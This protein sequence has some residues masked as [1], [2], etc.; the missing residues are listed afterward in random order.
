MPNCAKCGR[1]VATDT[2]EC[3]VCLQ[4]RIKADMMRL[5]ISTVAAEEEQRDGPSDRVKLLVAGTLSVCVLAFVLVVWSP[6]SRKG[7]AVASSPVTVAA[8]RPQPKAQTPQRSSASPSGQTRPVEPGASSPPSSRVYMPPVDNSPM[9]QMPS[10]DDWQPSTSNPQTQQERPAPAPEPS[11]R[12]VEA[13]DNYNLAVSDMLNLPAQIQLALAT[14]MSRNLVIGS[15][16]IATPETERLKAELSDLVSEALECERVFREENFNQFYRYY[17][18]AKPA[19]PQT[20]DYPHV[21][22]TYA[23]QVARFSFAKER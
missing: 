4:Q 22:D 16:R 1:T 3:Q 10:I 7:V 12:L 11:E 6:W 13:V 15:E 8:N 23:R 5:N 20:A 19:P 18:P 2:S 14:E 17:R 21:Y 9:P